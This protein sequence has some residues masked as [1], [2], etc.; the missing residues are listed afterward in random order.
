MSAV[1][2]VP[3]LVEAHDAVDILEGLPR[4]RKRMSGSE[5]VAIFSRKRPV[6]EATARHLQVVK[7]VLHHLVDGGLVERG[8][9]PGEGTRAGRW[10]L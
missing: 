7:P 4:R 10:H 5:V 8:A 9:D 3:V 2:F 6:G 1:C